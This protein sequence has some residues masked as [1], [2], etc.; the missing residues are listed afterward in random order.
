MSSVAASIEGADAGIDEIG[1]A[2]LVADEIG[3]DAELV[4][5]HLLEDRAVA[6]AVIHA[7]GDERDRARWVEAHLGEFIIAPAG[8]GD[9]GGDAEAED[10]AALL[11]GLAPLGDARVIGELQRVVEILGEVARI[12]DLLHRGRVRHRARGDGVAAAQLGGGNAELMRGLV[13][14]RLGDIDRLG[15]AAAAIG[16]DR[17]GVGQHRLHLRVDRREGIGVDEAAE[18]HRQRN[19]RPLG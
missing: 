10:L 16:R 2:I 19:G 8:R 9:R 15:P 11:G 5:Q 1:V 14:D 18:R 12:I 3:I 4:R 17:H 13:D 6:L 7:A